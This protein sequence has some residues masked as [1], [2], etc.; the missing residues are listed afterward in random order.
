MK[1]MVSTRPAS[2]GAWEFRTADMDILP[3]GDAFDRELS[4]RELLGAYASD[5]LGRHLTALLGDFRLSD[6]QNRTVLESGSVA[7]DAPAIDVTLDIEPVGRLQAAASTEILKATAGLLEILLQS[8]M[9]YHMASRL[10]EE[11]VSHDYQRLQQEHAAVLRSE[12]KYRTLAAELEAR[13]QEQV[14]TLKTAERQLYQAEKLAS[15]GQLAAGV[16]HE[17]NNPIG[18]IR[19][20][21]TS[22]SAYVKDISG[23]CAAIASGDGKQI[24]AAWNKA[25]ME[26]LLDDFQSLLQES[27]VGADRV[28]RIVSDLKGFSS[29]DQGQEERIDLNESIRTVC[30]V[31]GNGIQKKA[32]L[33]LDLGELPALQCQPG[34]INDVLLAMLLNAAQAVGEQG[35]I[36][37]STAVENGDICVRISDNG[38]GIAPENLSRIFDPFFTTR[39]VGAGTGLGL[40]V[41]RDIVRAHGGRIGVESRVG[42]GTTF[43]I[44]LPLKGR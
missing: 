29:I 6:E 5:R 15:V 7:A 28:A 36:R 30:N 33:V 9:R 2:F 32:Q 42:A 43:T 44:H 27:I 37:I 3:P 23:L 25:D 8:Q 16:A 19:S 35:E 22:A 34:S 18:F 20:N 13:V 38:C 40:T 24:V 1:V 17:I 39:E 41:C 4:L 31:A 10:H 12:L 26:F 11:Q 21:L 14:E